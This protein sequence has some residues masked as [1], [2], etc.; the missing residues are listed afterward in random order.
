MKK[1]ILLA[2]II[3][4][5]ASC[6]SPLNFQ[7]SKIG[8]EPDEYKQ[9]IIYSLPKTVLR[10]DIEIEKETYIPG[11]Y[12]QYAKRLLGLENVIQEYS[13]QYRINS[14]DLNSYNE[15]DPDL[16]F[17]VNVIKGSLMWDKYLS[18]TDR[19]F[20]LL[21]GESGFS[22]IKAE[23]MSVDNS[24]TSFQ[25][26][27]IK[28]N[29][30]EITDTL[31]KTIVSDTMLIRLPVVTTAQQVKTLEQKAIEAAKA[32]FLI[33]ENRFYTITNIDGDYP[34]GKAMEIMVK[35]M[36]KMEKAYL[37]LFAG[38]VVKQKYTQ[39]FIHSPESSE[40][41]Q[42]VS[43]CS[44]SA[45]NGL[46][47]KAGSYDLKLEL[48]PLN[49][50]PE[51]PSSAVASETPETNINKLIYRIPD[52]ATVRVKLMDE[53]LYENRIGI[54]QFGSLFDIPVTSAPLSNRLR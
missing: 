26:L 19:G 36:D 13:F 37:D 7:L 20:V 17:S 32:L 31:F 10:V 34:D 3:I 46:S 16:F 29:L 25:Q 14:V 33:R 51:M 28:T 15:S 18:L 47:D 11:P 50:L 1:Q 21:P 35:E 44:F 38:R 30:T 43:L 27:P 39:S 9:R 2:L 6:S 41:F 24:S 23:K 45:R 4:I 52:I 12:R 48:S 40:E 54:Y 22:P 5:A 49:G 53:V 8:E 42:S